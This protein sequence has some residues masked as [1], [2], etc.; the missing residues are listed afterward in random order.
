LAKLL[1]GVVC[2][3]IVAP[4]YAPSAIRRLSQKRNGNRWS[5]AARGRRM[6]G[7]RKRI[8]LRTPELASDASAD[9]SATGT[10]SHACDERAVRN[11]TKAHGYAA[12]TAGVSQRLW[13][14]DQRWCPSG[15][16]RR[17]TLAG[18]P[19]RGRER[20]PALPCRECHQWGV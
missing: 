18:V 6:D 10:H 1:M 15:A 4:G 14:S 17:R 9:R 7:L 2:E 5:T 8:V 13:A 12:L 16:S 20:R 11:Y 3:G 19:Y